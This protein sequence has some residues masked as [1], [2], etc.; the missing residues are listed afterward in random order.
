MGSHLF[1]SSYGEVR[2]DLLCACGSLRL[3]QVR[4][5]VVGHQ[6]LRPVGPPSDGCDDVLYGQG[7]V[8]GNIAPPDIPPLPSCIQL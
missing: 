7:V 2:R 5:E 8:R 6:Q 4:I 3:H 1:Q